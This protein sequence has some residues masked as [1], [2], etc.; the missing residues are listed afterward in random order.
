MN[1]E[2]NKPPKTMNKK[3]LM[4]WYADEIKSRFGISHKEQAK[5]FGISKFVFSNMVN[6]QRTIVDESLLDKF[7]E[8]YLE[9]L[10]DELP[11]M[12]KINDFLQRKN[13]ELQFKVDQLEK[14]IKFLRNN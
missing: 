13:I 4:I 5:R 2:E 14:E 9:C 11:E 12:V 7:K 1:S 3:Q 10:R 8:L 6:S